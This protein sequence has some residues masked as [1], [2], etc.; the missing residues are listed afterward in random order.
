VI[1]AVW[2]KK[3]VQ[4]LLKPFGKFFSEELK[5]IGV[6]LGQVQRRKID[7]CSIASGKTDKFVTRMKRNA[8]L[9]FLLAERS[10]A[11]SIDEGGLLV[12]NSDHTNLHKRSFLRGLKGHFVQNRLLYEIWLFFVSVMQKKN[13]GV[14]LV[15][16]GTPDSPRQSD[17]K[18]YL[19][20]FLT[21][22]RVID[23]PFLLRHSLVR[24]VI[25]PRRIKNTTASYQAV[26]SEKGSP[27]KQYGKEV[28]TLLQKAL[29]ES[30]KVIL[31]MRYQ[32]PSI[33]EG[34]D[35]LKGC[36]EI[37][38]FPLFPQY[39]SATTG[40]VHQEVMRIVSKWEVIPAMKFLS[41]YPTAPKMI[42]TF[43]ANAKKYPTETYDH[44]LFSFHGLPK[45]QI[46]KGD[47]SGRCKL[48]GECCKTLSEGNRYC[49]SA[50]CFATAQAIAKELGLPKE[51]WTITFQSRLGKDP[52]MDPFTNDKIKE[53]AEKGAKRLLVFSP[54]FVADCL[55]TLFEIKEEYRLEFCAHGGE[56]LDL[57]ESLNTHPSWIEAMKSLISP[58]VS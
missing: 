37:V 50:Q 8:R 27:L 24:G 15:N 5:E 29:G 26:W 22:G 25:I 21:D 10:K 35:Q 9:K 30:Y 52:W 49:Y 11:L 45:R 14:L 18:K 58:S 57:V 6:G 41:E 40:S 43:A 1:K 51:K 19:T 55:E 42:A 7:F 23:R 36:E 53:F 13:V 46:R 17:V 54:S 31:A 47:Q 4:P 56:T 32:S 20:E 48:D 34:L 33:Q 39:A 44:I 2:T 38:I 16:L 28:T 3:S 12:V